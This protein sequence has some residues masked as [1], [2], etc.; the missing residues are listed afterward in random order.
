[1]LRRTRMQLPTAT[2]LPQ[3]SWW[4]PREDQVKET[5]SQGLLWPHS[6]GSTQIRGRPGN[7]S[8]TTPEE[9]DME[10]SNLSTVTVRQ[11]LPSAKRQEN[12]A[13]E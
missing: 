13:E 3:S 7:Q 12:S 4:S 11:F 8:C 9:P 10:D 1:M 6:Q 2:S 5:K